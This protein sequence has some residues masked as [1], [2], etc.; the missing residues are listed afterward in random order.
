MNSLFRFPVRFVLAMPLI[1]MGH[2]ATPVAARIYS[3]RFRN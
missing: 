1:G 2:I 3:P